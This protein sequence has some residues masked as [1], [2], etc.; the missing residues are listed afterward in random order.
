MKLKIAL[1]TFLVFVTFQA[2]ANS[3]DATAEIH[4]KPK[5]SIVID[6]LGDN[7]IIAK[8]LLSLSGEFTAAILPHT[9]HAKPIAEF[10]QENG[11]EVI[12]H[13]PMEAMTRPDL[14]G[15]GA[16]Y[17]NMDKAQ[18][19][20]TFLDSAAT[21]PNM[22]GFNNHMGS[23]LTVDEE[24]MRWVMESAKQKGWY[25]LDSKTTVSSIA[26]DVAQDL[27]L[28]T[29]GRDV[30]LDHHSFA[31]KSN[32]S[33][34]IEKRMAQAMRIAERRGEV[35]V[36]CHP[37]PDTLKYLQENLP[38]I[39]EKFRVVKLSLLLNSQEMTKPTAP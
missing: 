19:L 35:V 15:P 22:V 4:V 9:P 33:E 29:I 21:V 27:G 26:Q 8:Q 13:I 10:A 12:M 38:L 1:L 5:L 16:L 37:Y 30:F 14:L 17:A 20:E 7:S 32:L 28:P 23:L 18:F 34:V 11:H 25:F 2:F 39:E 36:I 3:L 6:D 24:K 31:E